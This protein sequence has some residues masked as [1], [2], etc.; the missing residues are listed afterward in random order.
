MIDTPLE[1]PSDGTATPASGPGIW[2]CTGNGSI[3]GPY[4]FIRS[5]C[6]GREVT[7]TT[8]N[9]CGS[10]RAPAIPGEKGRLP[11]ICGECARM[12]GKYASLHLF[13]AKVPALA[14]LEG[15]SRLGDWQFP[16]PLAG[17]L[18]LFDREQDRLGSY[19]LLNLIGLA[20]L[21]RNRT[22]AWARVQEL[23]LL[24]AATGYKRAQF[25][26][27]SFRERYALPVEVPV[28]PG[29]S[30]A[31]GSMEG[32]AGDEEKTTGFVT[33]FQS[34]LSSR[35][36]TFHPGYARDILGRLCRMIEQK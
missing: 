6:A 14:V 24:V 20:S 21:A 28:L 27:K 10:G 18:I 15:R 29:P 13:S 26:E 34:I 32:A 2:V 3:I 31:A 12:S 25:D 36:A 22:L 7:T 16:V 30:M 17:L 33:F 23:P 1:K 5:A 11:L 19:R 9:W 8:A 35:K 4:L